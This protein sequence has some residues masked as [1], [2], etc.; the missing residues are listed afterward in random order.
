MK[1]ASYFYP[2]ATIAM[3]AG[4]SRSQGFSYITGSEQS[5]PGI[6]DQEDHPYK[7]G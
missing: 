5:R 1:T 2:E 4:R 6:P 3:Q 7:D